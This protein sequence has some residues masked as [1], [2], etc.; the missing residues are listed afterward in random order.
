M[1]LWADVTTLADG[2]ARGT[3]SALEL[4]QAM[5]E[6]A[7]QWQPRFRAYATDRKSVV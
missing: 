3:F 6:R 2:L 4:A 1:N 5:N 7:A